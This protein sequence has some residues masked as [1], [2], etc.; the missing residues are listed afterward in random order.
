MKISLSTSVFQSNRENT[1]KRI[2]IALLLAAT[3][4]A[5]TATASE[6]ESLVWTSVVIQCGKTPEAGD[7]SCEIKTG[8]KGWEKFVI[9]AFGKTHSLSSTDLATLEGFP[10][11]SLRTSHEA[12]YEILGGHT[13]SFRFDRTFYNPQKKLVTEIIYVSVTKNGVTVSDRQTKE[14]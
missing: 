12:G 10:L 8:E 14:H 2:M 1:M 9:Q 6:A 11:S 4:P 3:T 5:F 7:I 13:V